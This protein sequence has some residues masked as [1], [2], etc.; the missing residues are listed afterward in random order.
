MFIILHNV[1]YGV[2]AWDGV[3]N[4]G[5]GGARCNSRSGSGGTLGFTLYIKILEGSKQNIFNMFN[6]NSYLKISKNLH[7]VMV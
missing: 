2:C 6:T 7:K 5:G 3:E 4:E 1:Q